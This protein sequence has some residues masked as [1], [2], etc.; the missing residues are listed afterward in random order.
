VAHKTLTISEEAYRALFQ[1]KNGNESFTEVIL[2]L[3][4]RKELGKL[5]EYIKRSE[6]DKELARNIESA[7]RR[8][9]LSRFRRVKL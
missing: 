5:S 3:T 1:L 9:R 4:K 6:P 7:S 2:R 8:L